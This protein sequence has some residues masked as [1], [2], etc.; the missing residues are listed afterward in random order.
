VSSVLDA[1]RSGKHRAGRAYRD[2]PRRDARR[3]GAS[4][5]TTD[6][7]DSTPTSTTRTMPPTRR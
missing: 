3:Y 5:E 4:T 1:A 6:I 7:G 2:M